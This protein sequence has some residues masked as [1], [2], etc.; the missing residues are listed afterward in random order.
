VGA[1][2]ICSPFISKKAMAV[3]AWM[4]GLD[5]RRTVVLEVEPARA[6]RVQG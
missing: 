2:F 3:V 6:M 5:V 1:T 4:T